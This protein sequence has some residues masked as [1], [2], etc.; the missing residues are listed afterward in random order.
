[1]AYPEFIILLTNLSESE[2]QIVIGLL[3]RCLFVVKMVESPQFCWYF[4]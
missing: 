3:F 1:V 4:K 2:I